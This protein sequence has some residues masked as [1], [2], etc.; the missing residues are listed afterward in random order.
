MKNISS[1]PLILFYSC[2]RCFNNSDGDF[3]I[4]EERSA[5]VFSLSSIIRTMIAQTLACLLVQ[6]FFSL[7]L[8]LSVCVRSPS[9]GRDLDHHRVWE[10]DGRAER[11]LCHPGGLYVFH[12]PCFQRNLPLCLPQHPTY[13]I[14][15]GIVWCFLKVTSKI[16]DGGKEVLSYRK[17]DHLDSSTCAFQSPFRTETAHS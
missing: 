12:F 8:S 17:P 2:S 15:K 5:V 3:L 6:I 13:H 4:G 16:S 9:A 1:L 11:D 7:C 14:Q 10:D